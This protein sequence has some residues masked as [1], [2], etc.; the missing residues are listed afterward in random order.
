MAE[1]LTRL[2]NLLSKIQQIEPISNVN[3]CSRLKK[4]ILMIEYA[5]APK[6]QDGKDLSIAMRAV[7][8]LSHFT[9]LFGEDNVA[10]CF[11]NILQL[12]NDAMAILQKNTQPLVQSDGKEFASI[13]VQMVS[14]GNQLHLRLEGS[15]FNNSGSQQE[16]DKDKQLYERALKAHQKAQ[17]DN[18]NIPINPEIIEKIIVLCGD[19]RSIADKAAQNQRRCTRLAKRIKYMEL[20]LSPPTN[21]NDEEI[22]LDVRV[23][24]ALYL[25]TNTLSLNHKEIMDQLYLL[26]ATLKSAYDEIFRNTPLFGDNWRRLTHS[27]KIDKFGPMNKQL[28]SCCMALKLAQHHLDIFD[29]KLDAQDM[30]HDLPDLDRKAIAALFFMFKFIY[31][32]MNEKRT[33]PHRC[34]RLLDRV[35]KIDAVI[36][37]TQENQPTPTIDLRISNTVN[38][39]CSLGQ[40]A[41]MGSTVNMLQNT[42]EEV[43][44]HLQ[45][46]GSDATPVKV[47]DKLIQSDDSDFIKL[48]TYL[49]QCLELMYLEKHIPKIFSEK[50]DEE[51]KEKDYAILKGIQKRLQ[52]EEEER[53]RLER[54]RNKHLIGRE[55]LSPGRAEYERGM[56]LYQGII[57][58]QDLPQAFDFFQRSADL[59]DPDGMMMLALFYS[60]GRATKVQLELAFAWYLKAAHTNAMKAKLIVAECYEKGTGCP[61]NEVEASKWYLSAAEAGNSDAQF[62]VAQRYEQGKGFT[63]DDL[64]KQWYKRAAYTFLKEAEEGS[65]SSATKLAK[66]Y[67][68]GH[69]VVQDYVAA[70]QWIQIAA[71]KNDPEADYIAGLMHEQGKGTQANPQ[72]AFEFYSK[73]ARRDHPLGIYSLGTCYEKGSGVERDMKTAILYY[74]QAADLK[75]PEA[76]LQIGI[77]HEKGGYGVDQS[78]AKAFELYKQVLD[79]CPEACCKLGQLYEYG[80]GVQKDTKEAFKIYQRGAKQGNPSAQYNLG[81]CYETGTGVIKDDREAFDWYEKAAQQNHASAL[82]NLGL[83]FHR[84]I[85]CPQNLDKAFSYLMRSAQLNKP[86]AQYWV[87]YCYEQGLG[88]R[89]DYAQAVNW[90]EQAAVKGDILAQN[91]YAFC[92][93]SG[94]G[95]GTDF[96]KAMLWFEKAASQGNPTAMYNL[97]TCYE[98]GLTGKKDLPKAIQWYE[99]ASHLGNADAQNNLGMLY[100]AGNG[101]EKN[102]QKAFE[103]YSKSAEQNNGAAQLSLAVCYEKGIGINA[104]LEKAADYFQRAIKN[105]K[106]AAQK[107]LDALLTK[108]PRG[109]LTTSTTEKPRSRKSSARPKSGESD[110]KK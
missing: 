30:K 97:A 28:Y 110:V 109:R 43:Y 7:N 39:L 23:E 85:G 91:N 36:S 44:A 65:V 93:K 3:Q 55:H 96:E 49:R 84:G 18:A 72:K 42:L 41:E 46:H 108:L 103:L 15:E 101:V 67:L 99:K 105:G 56:E 70:L 11:D 12:A 87:G 86:S 34:Q 27:S 92:L 35:K 90:Y 74:K 37:P 50:E 52:E 75:V 16:L 81:Y 62:I 71:S 5:I 73:A 25:L 64:S 104:N 58:S 57:E 24:D 45:L 32:I 76:I 29:P 4:R 69:G 63:G 21:G 77:A 68:N 6:N 79:S 14:C 61:H 89:Q 19:I 53:L 17:D 48:N 82:R 66:C 9:E 88:T 98:A 26:S 100:E 95:V 60:T 83:L 40:S 38:F 47:T 31:E 54:E 102:L 80:R 78:Y 2:L 94:K 20:S 13:L 59:G 51:D 107:R 106:T 8:T 1:N 33:N 10:G 22:P